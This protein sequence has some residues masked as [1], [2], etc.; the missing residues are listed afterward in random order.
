MGK[1]TGLPFTA[2]HVSSSPSFVSSR[3]LRPFPNLKS[4]QSCCS[5]R[6][7]L[8]QLRCSPNLHTTHRYKLCR[9]SYPRH[10]CVDTSRTSPAIAASGDVSCR[11]C[12]LLAAGAARDV[13]VPVRT[14]AASMQAKYH[15][16]NHGPW[17][18]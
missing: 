1:K 15:P 3:S 14:P 9:L 16:N 6:N 17:G 7:L 12:E 8:M 10:R 11:P 2:A 4:W 13:P 5:L 18:E